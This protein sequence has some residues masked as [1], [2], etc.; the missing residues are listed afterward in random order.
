VSKAAISALML[1]VNEQA[2]LGAKPT[3]CDLL[4]GSSK[5]EETTLTRPPANKQQRI[6][7]SNHNNPCTSMQQMTDGKSGTCSHTDDA[8][9]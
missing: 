9:C 4:N 8:D 6:V 2:Q 3:G 7:N 5:E 1:V